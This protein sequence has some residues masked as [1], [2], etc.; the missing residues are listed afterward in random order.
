MLQD[1]DQLAVRIGQLVERTRQLHQ[2]R[3]SLRVRVHQI[4]QEN[5]QARERCEKSE[6]RLQVLQEQVQCHGS[7]LASKLSQ[8]E[9]CENGLR[10]ELKK[11]IDQQQ[12]LEAQWAAQ[13]SEW[14]ARLNIRDADLQG[15]RRTTAIARERIDAVLARLPG[16]PLEE[17]R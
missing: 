9:A 1:L 17:Q 3:E 6:A 12:A 14:Q 11:H 5:R 2:E 7:E 4:E 13:E 10:T 15:L 16:A 8:A